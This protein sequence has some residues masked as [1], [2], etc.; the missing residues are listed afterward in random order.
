[1]TPKGKEKLAASTTVSL[2]IYE[3]LSSG[4]SKT[5]L[6]EFNTLLVKLMKNTEKLLAP[7]KPIKKRKI[8]Q[9]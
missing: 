7:P 1:M 5:E 2:A 6:K 3:K 4:F 9:D 8:Y